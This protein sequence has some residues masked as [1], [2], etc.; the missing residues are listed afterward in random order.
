VR[1]FNEGGELPNGKTQQHV[2]TPNDG[3][4]IGIAVIWQMETR[5]SRPRYSFVMATVPPNQLIGAITDRMPAV[6][7]ETDWPAWL[8]EEEAS[9]GELKALLRAFEGDWTMQP[10][11]KPRKSRP[12]ETPLL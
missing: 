5:D 7:E 1:T 9:V 4:P 8:G 2:V 10:Q 3:K 12:R 6:L 11:E